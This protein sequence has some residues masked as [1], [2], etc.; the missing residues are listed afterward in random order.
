[1]H[2][3]L[4]D[5]LVR[6]YQYEHLRSDPEIVSALVILIG[7]QSAP[8]RIWHRMRFVTDHKPKNRCAR[9]EARDHSAT[10]GDSRLGL[11]QDRSN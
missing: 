9:A 10:L 2:D 5:D 4:T 7:E 3:H 11:N 1:M 8:N 6:N